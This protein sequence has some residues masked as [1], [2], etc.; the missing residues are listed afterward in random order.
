MH[1]NQTTKGQVPLERVEIHF[2]QDWSK[3]S[4][5]IIKGKNIDVPKTWPDDDKKFNPENSPGFIAFLLA[6]V[7][8]AQ[9]GMPTGKRV[10][11]ESPARAF[12]SLHKGIANSEG[13]WRATWL[14]FPNCDK[15]IINGIFQGK[16]EEK[17]QKYHVDLIQPFDVVVQADGQNSDFSKARDSLEKLFERAE[18]KQGVSRTGT[19]LSPQKP[20]G[21]PPIRCHKW[22]SRPA[23]E[24]SLR[25]ALTSQ[26][27]VV[28]VFGEEGTGKAETLR[29]VLEELNPPLPYQI[30]WIDIRPTDSVKALDVSQILAELGRKLGLK[31]LLPDNTPDLDS[32][33]EE[34]S[35]QAVLIVLQRYE[36]L[37][38]PEF[39]QWLASL[40]TCMDGAIR[41]MT[42]R[43]PA[44]RFK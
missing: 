28:W 6:C 11:D 34:L 2:E 41:Q 15:P 18:K 24:K 17:T 20:R 5:V 19:T 21:L 36:E 44:K 26:K 1:I 16:Y 29:H 35:Q 27:P 25:E 10:L 43:F 3:L 38:S 9:K 8:A 14:F 32:A 12:F 31:K 23:T 13:T 4:K 33:A 22:I 40:H 30:V 37:K 42:R 7:C 39:F